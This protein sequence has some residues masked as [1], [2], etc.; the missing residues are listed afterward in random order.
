MTWGMN[1]RQLTREDPNR[2][3][4]SGTPL[5]NGRCSVCNQSVRL[6]NRGEVAALHSLPAWKRE[7]MATGDV[8]PAGRGA[9]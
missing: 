2:C 9:E 3:P 8:L 4:G 1:Q 6:R 5:V 7:Q